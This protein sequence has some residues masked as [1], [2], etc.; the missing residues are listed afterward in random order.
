M[1][2]LVN[3][4]D[5]SP[6]QRDTAS[7]LRRLLGKAITDRYVDFCR[8]AGG[9]FAINVSRPLA[10]HA[11]RE[12]DSMLRH[13]LEVPMEAKAPEQA[14]DAGKLNEARKQLS[15]LG[16]DDASVQ[17]VLNGLKPRLTHKEQIRKIVACLGLDPAGDIANKWTSLSDSFGKA[18]QRSFHL[19][20]ENTAFSLG[21]QFFENL[22]LISL[23]HF[24]GALHGSGSIHFRLSFAIQ[25]GAAAA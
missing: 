5:L 16:F 9:A 25:A 24:G 4:F 21:H 11:L 18:H 1:E 15:A 13:V 8:L 7:L 14:E 3:A 6:E 2:G 17:R 22:S 12:L 10:A 19:A 20:A 23:S